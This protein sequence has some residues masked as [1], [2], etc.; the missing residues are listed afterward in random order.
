[1]VLVYVDDILVIFSKE[2]KKVTMDE[3]GKV[4]L[5]N[6]KVEW[7]MGSRTYLKNAVRVVES[8]IA[9]YDPEA[10]LKSTARNPF[11][12][13][14]KPNIDVTSEGAETKYHS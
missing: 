14:Y 6:G 8:L 5:P 2:P 7:A 13:G 3:S 11:P 1:M 9:E 12:T 4:Q 10:K